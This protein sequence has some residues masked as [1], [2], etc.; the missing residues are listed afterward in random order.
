MGSVELHELYFGNLGGF[1]R[2][3]AGAGLGSSE[4]H[5]LPDAFAAA[6][7]A[8]FGSA[9]AWRREFVRMAQSLPGGPGWVL[10]TYSRSPST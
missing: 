5:E 7:A 4:W 10:L 3:G 6:I 2:A 1:T 8:D 9:G